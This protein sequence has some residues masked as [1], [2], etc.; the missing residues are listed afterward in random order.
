MKNSHNETVHGS[1][2]LESYE[3]DGSTVSREVTEID[4][5]ACDHDCHNCPCEGVCAQNGG[6]AK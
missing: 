3:E 6:N 2:F 5:I 1:S 4:N